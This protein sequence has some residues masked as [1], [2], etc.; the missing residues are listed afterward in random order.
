M[1]KKSVYREDLDTF[2]EPCYTHK[3]RCCFYSGVRIATS[4]SQEGRSQR[5]YARYM[6]YW[7]DGLQS[8][9][10]PQISHYR[11]ISN[12]NLGKIRLSI[13][14][15]ILQGISKR[16]ETSEKEADAE[17]DTCDYSE[18][19]DYCVPAEHAWQVST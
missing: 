11:I 12:G 15:G 14:S 13:Q 5:S 9:S 10:T 7:A 17:M 4:T 19:Q 8:Q 3:R 6:S 18:R 16:T 2:T 1:P